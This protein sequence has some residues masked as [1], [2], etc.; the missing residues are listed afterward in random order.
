MTFAAMVCCREED[1]AM[2]PFFMCQW[3][4]IYPDVPLWLANDYANPVINTRG[5]PLTKKVKW[6]KGVGRE[7]VEAMLS[8]GADIVA[9]VDVDGWHQEQYLFA[10]FADENVM[11]CGI[12]W[13]N[14][15]GRFL[16]IG[17]A[18]RRKAL[19]LIEMSNSCG[20]W[21]SSQ[22]DFSVCN[23]IRFA[24][25]N[26]VFLYKNKHC[27]RADTDPSSSFVVHCGIHGR[28]DKGRKLA[29]GE[30][31]NLSEGN[32]VVATFAEIW[33]GL[34]VMPDR[35]SSAQKVLNGLLAN[36]L[37]PTGIVVAIP[38][39]LKRTGQEYSLEFLESIS[40]IDDRI[41]IVRCEDNGP[42][43]K[44]LELV[45]YVSNPKALCI[46]VDDDINYS[47]QFIQRMSANY[48][49][50]DDEVISNNV[51]RVRGFDWVVPEG[52]SGVGFMRDVIKLPHFES[53]IEF[54]KQNTESFLAD[55]ALMGF[56]FNLIGANVS[57]SITQ[58]FTTP[59]NENYDENALHKIGKGHLSRYRQV[60]DWLNKNVHTFEYAM[61]QQLENK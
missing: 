49:A 4:K 52:F 55:D 27:R 34:S 26:G 54:S 59:M 8:T 56:Y 20:D 25:P 28:N 18:V 37:A 43:T 48:M 33:I 51:L 35:L 42:V 32:P 29:L 3:S 12:A 24:F 9:K 6:G 16:G 38:H 45:K 7:M 31:F 41:K 58:I 1:A 44:Y 21:V 47:P 60:I 30:M 53:Y 5:L 11:A 23:A 40:S 14:D 46:I 2:L 61:P 39:V 57:S 13:I 17:Y 19:S 15:P 10:P 22:E 36:T 50:V